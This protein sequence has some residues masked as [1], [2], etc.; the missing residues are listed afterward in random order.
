MSSTNESS[1]PSPPHP[2]T[3]HSVTEFECLDSWDTLGI[4]YLRDVPTPPPP[5][6]LLRSYYDWMRHY[7]HYQITKRPL[8]RIIRPDISHCIRDPMLRELASNPHHISDCVYCQIHHH[9]PGSIV[10][11]CEDSPEL[12]VTFH[13]HWTTRTYCLKCKHRQCFTC[14]VLLLEESYLVIQQHEQTEE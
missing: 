5:Q 2:N 9:T 3:P 12:Q 8:A 13:N 7:G 4:S 14:P 10:C 1:P 11:V 6:P